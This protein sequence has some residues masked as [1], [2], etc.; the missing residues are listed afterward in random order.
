VRGYDVSNLTLIRGQTGWIVVDVLTAR[1]T[2]AA[3][4][5][6]ARAHLGELPIRAVVLT[7]SHLDH[8]GGI[9]AVLPPGEARDGVRIVAPRGF[10]EEATSENPRP[11]SWWPSTS[12]SPTRARRTW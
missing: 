5:A 2:A 10:V 4:L 7:H 9:E 12:S 6:L 8:F 1:E 11:A 3:A